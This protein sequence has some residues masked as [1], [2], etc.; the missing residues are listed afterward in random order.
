MITWAFSLVGPDDL[1]WRGSPAWPWLWSGWPHAHSSKATQPG[2]GPVWTGLVR[3]FRSEE[4]RLRPGHAP[5]GALPGW[6]AVG[7]SV[8]GTWGNAASIYIIPGQG[9]RKWKI[10]MSGD[11]L[12]RVNLNLR[13]LHNYCLH[14][15]QGFLVGIRNQFNCGGQI[16]RPTIKQLIVCHSAQIL[17]MA[18]D[19][20]PRRN[21]KDGI[22]D[23]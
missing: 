5:G 9:K 17:H 1:S 20:E 13:V 21:S 23:F 8:L 19:K 14:H 15:K 12:I 18:G 16:S 3:S 6:H 2:F 7:Q 10:P 22:P 11:S 4:R